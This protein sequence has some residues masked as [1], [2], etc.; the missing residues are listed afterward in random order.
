MS[1]LYER[2]AAQNDGSI[3]NVL[4]HF[5]HLYRLILIQSE[6]VIVINNLV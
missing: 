3:D 5:T 6:N 4:P 2:P 1:T